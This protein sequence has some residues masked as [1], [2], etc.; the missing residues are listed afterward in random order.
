MSEPGGHT[1]DRPSIWWKPA[2]FSNDRPLSRHL[3]TP[4]TYQEA[5]GWP[6]ARLRT[7]CGLVIPRLAL[8]GAPDGPTRPV[9]REGEQLRLCGRCQRIQAS[10]DARGE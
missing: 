10:R 6:D 7:V 3:W 5:R 9:V 4:V 1:D 8:P 2:T